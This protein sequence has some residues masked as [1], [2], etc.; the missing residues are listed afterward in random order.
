MDSGL[1]L[2]NFADVRES[3]FK[4]D[5][6]MPI[7]EYKCESCGYVFEYMAKNTQDRAGECAECGSANVKKLFSAFAPSS[8]D[9]GNEGTACVPGSSCSAGGDDS[10]CASGNCPF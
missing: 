10:P 6:P 1:G 8:S 2:I 7:Y 3:Q 9:S 4:E 5:T